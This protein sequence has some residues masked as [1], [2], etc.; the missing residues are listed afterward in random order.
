MEGA[1]EELTYDKLNKSV[2]NIYTLYSTVKI[3]VFTEQ[4]IN[5]AA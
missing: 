3:K 4:S 5:Q 2:K 1:V